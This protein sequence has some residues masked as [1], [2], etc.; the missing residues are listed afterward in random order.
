MR[1][2]VSL[3]LGI[4]SAFAAGSFA[5]EAQPKPEEKPVGEQGQ[6][7]PT[8]QPAQEPAPAPKPAAEQPAQPQP[9]AEP[10][11]AAEPQP[12]AEAQPVAEPQ[13]AAQ[14]QPAVQQQPAQPAAPAQPSKDAAPAAQPATVKAP[15]LPSLNISA[16]EMER[17]I[18]I[19]MAAKGRARGLTLLDS[20]RGFMNALASMDGKG[21]AGGTGFSLRVFTP[22]AWMEQEAS[23]AAKEY[24]TLT[25]ADFDENFQQPVL[26]VLV[27]PDTPTEVTAKGMRQTSSVQHVV[28]RDANKEDRDPAAIQG[29]A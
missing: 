14:Q 29:H 8:P 27:N 4:V 22:V 12:A 13:P 9:A 15:A 26:R 3:L 2:R 24:R 1:V 23:D 25:P 16:L 19:G 28:L 7:E 18:K 20:G 10:E 6:V 5:Q 21:G 17:A 11:P